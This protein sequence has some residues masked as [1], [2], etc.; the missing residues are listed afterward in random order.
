MSNTN[1]TECSAEITGDNRWLLT[2]RWESETGSSGLIMFVGLNPSTADGE[3]D[4]PT[5][6]K[7]VGFAK[8][9][10]FGGLLKVN[11]F[12]HRATDPKDLLAW[13]RNPASEIT[14][15]DNDLIIQKTVERCST[16]VA[17]WGGMAMH[18]RVFLYSHRAMK[19]LEKHDRLFCLGKT[20]RGCPRHPLYLRNDTRLVRFP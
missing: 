18:S 7:E 20:R 14:C 13:L 2:R 16:V 4:D 5:I 6:R 1:Y 19:I 8:R 17:A 11:L 3:S 10:G 12:P 9:M 15:A